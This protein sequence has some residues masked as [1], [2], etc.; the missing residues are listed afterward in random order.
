MKTTGKRYV[1]SV[2]IRDRVGILR[3]I[4]A[5][6]TDLGANIDGISQTVVAGYFTVI[7]TAT[8]RKVQTPTAIQEAVHG[9]FPAD[10]ASVVVR[11]YEGQGAA[12]RTVEGEGYIV[13]ISGKDRPGILKAITAFM[14]DKGLNIEDW[15]VGFEGDG[16]VTHIGE[17]TVPSVLD[18]KQVQDEFKQVVAPMKLKLSMQHGNIFRATNEI[19]PIKSLLGGHP[20]A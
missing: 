17:V 20:H 8:F 11:P 19:G 1:I 6:V 5:A 10:E 7:L 2:L 13:T 14:A 18:I 15:Y 9:Q 12:K 16:F 4:S 3:A